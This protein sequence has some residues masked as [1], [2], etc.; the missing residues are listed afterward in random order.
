MK[1]LQKEKE[2]MKKQFNGRFLTFIATGELSQD[3]TCTFTLNSI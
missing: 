2:L 1:K 3:N